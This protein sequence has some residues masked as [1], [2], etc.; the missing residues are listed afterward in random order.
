MRPARAGRQATPHGPSC[1]GYTRRRIL[2]AMTSITFVATAGCLGSETEDTDPDPIDLTEGQT[3]AVCG[4]VIE[5]YH[6]PAA[7]AY[8][9]ESPLEGS[10]PVPFD[11]VAEFVTFDIDQRSRGNERIAAF[12]TDYSAVSFDLEEQSEGIY[13]STHA[14]ASDFAPIEDLLYVIDSDILGA[15]GDDALP[16]SDQDQASEITSQYGGTVVNWSRLEEG[17]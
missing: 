4:M 6:G 8:Y 15:M 16:F 11:S 2:K 17:L 13:I 10:G 3:C 7:Q 1:S 14:Q 5:D 9:D 12:A